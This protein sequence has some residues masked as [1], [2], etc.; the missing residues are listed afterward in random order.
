M[1]INIPSDLP[2]TAALK[3]ENIFVMSQERALAQDIRPLRILLLN[4]MPKKIETETQILRL[5]S[6]SPLQ[7]D[8]ELLQTASHTSRNTSSRH[9][10]KFYKT[11][12]DVEQSYFDGMIV[13]GAPVE[14]MKFSQIDYW[15]ELVYILR[16]ARS[17]VFSSFHICWGAVA[18]LYVYYQIPR[19]VQAQK[20]FGVFEHHVD[21]PHHP[22]VRGF[23][24]TFFVPHSRYFFLDEKDL[25][26]CGQLEVL[27]SSRISGVHI[28]SS[29]DGRNY[30]V[31]GHS[32][33]D[34]YTLANEYRRDLQRC[35]SPQIPVSYFP[36]NN[37][38]QTP[39]YNWR[40]HANLMFSNWLNYVVYQNTPFHLSQLNDMLAE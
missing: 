27:T 11:I 15:N 2:A 39:I 19:R 29:T 38:E 9:M 32:E 17:H 14:R 16:W 18:A 35:K 31:T 23:D 28:A 3:K 40:C 7:I 5:L 37:P 22:L 21:L 1:P 13:T 36:N 10:L 12:G 20:L 24:E 25:R 6:N 30:F 33:Y 26:Q 34:R 8:V 4:L